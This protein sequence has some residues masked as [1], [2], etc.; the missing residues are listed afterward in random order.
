M[1]E[2]GGGGPGFGGR[3]GGGGGL[4]WRDQAI[5]NGWGYGNI[6]P[7]SIQPDNNRLRTGI[8]G[9]AN[10]GEPRKPDDWG[11]LR[12][13]QWGVS[14]LIDYFEA[15]PDSMVDAK[16]IGIEGLS[17]YGR[18][19]SSKPSNLDRCGPHRFF[20][21]RRRKLH[22]HIYGEAVRTS[23]VAEL[24]MP[25][26]SQVWRVRADETAADLPVNL[27]LIALAPPVLH[28]LRR[29]E[30]GDAKWWMRTEFHGRSSGRPVP[31]ARQKRFLH[32]WR[33]PH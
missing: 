20:R 11:A 14:R 19:R 16:K 17:R 12:A 29:V 27:E 32:S 33:L 8:I 26:T 1:I 30:R 6:N 15:H 21:R 7:N 23:R 4:S 25:A 9:L 3:R 10:K 13:W 18:R 28:Q 22:R 31:A 2:F 5:T 24:L